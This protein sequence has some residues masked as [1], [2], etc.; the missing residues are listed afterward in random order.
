MW[1]R[2]GGDVREFRPKTSATERFKFIMNMYSLM[3]RPGCHRYVRSS[4]DYDYLGLCATCL[5]DT[6][7]L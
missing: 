3:P 1:C 5:Q 4:F 7:V 2:T 6:S